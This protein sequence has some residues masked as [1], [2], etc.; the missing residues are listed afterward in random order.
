MD[1]A[2]QTMIDNLPEKTGSSLEQWHALLK[3][4]SFNK[5]S[6][7]VNFLKAEH[8]IGHGYANTIVT[9]AKADNTSEQELVE[10][11]YKGKEQ[12]IPLY[13]R[14]LEI[15]KPLGPDITITPKK[16][17]VSVIRK[18]QFVLIKPATKT[19][20]DLGLKLKGVENQ[21]KLGDSGPFGTMCSHRIQLTA[22]SQIDKEVINW[23]KLAYENSQ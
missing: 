2:L 3:Q 11:Q 18:H 7:A 9:L 17:S 1:K 6:E 20:I 4:H 5:H 13:H 8:G 19:R 14:L 15:I 21:G 16:T 12:L 22:L 23:I 10:L